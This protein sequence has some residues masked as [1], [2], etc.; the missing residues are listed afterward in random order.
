MRYRAFFDGCSRLVDMVS[1]AVRFLW[2][3]RLPTGLLF[4][5]CWSKFYCSDSWLDYLYVRLVCGG[6]WHRATDVLSVAQVVNSLSFT[7][8]TQDQPFFLH[9]IVLSGRRYLFRLLHCLISEHLTFRAT[10]KLAITRSPS[11]SVL[12]VTRAWYALRSIGRL[13]KVVWVLVFR[14]CAQLDAIRKAL[15]HD[16]VSFN[17]I[18]AAAWLLLKRRTG[19]FF[20]AKCLQLGETL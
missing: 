13:F 12:I 6:P 11:H 18:T 5:L 15:F 3:Y 2:L 16:L 9:W 4:R 1:T 14:E 19:V 10:S 7:Q 17:P 8:M 20:P